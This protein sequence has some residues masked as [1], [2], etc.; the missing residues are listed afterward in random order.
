MVD[1]DLEGLRSRRRRKLSLGVDFSRVERRFRR[2][3]ERKPSP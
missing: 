3:V 1:R 2:G